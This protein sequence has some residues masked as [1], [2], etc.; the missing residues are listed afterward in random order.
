MFEAQLLTLAL[1]LV[2]IK[3]NKRALLLAPALPSLLT[4]VLMTYVGEKISPLIQAGDV[5]SGGYQ[6]TYYL[7]FPAIAMFL[8]AFLVNEV[9]RK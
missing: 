4:A 2:S 6:L 1:G 7:V 3:Y 5:I 8:L 9:A